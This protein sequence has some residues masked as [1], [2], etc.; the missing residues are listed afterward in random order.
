M[1]NKYATCSISSSNFAR[2]TD[3]RHQGAIIATTHAECGTINACCKFCIT[4][5]FKLISPSPPLQSHILRHLPRPLAH[6]VSY[7][8]P[9]PP[10]PSWFSLGFLWRRAMMR[11]LRGTLNVTW[12]VCVCVCVGKQHRFCFHF[13]AGCISELSMRRSAFC[14]I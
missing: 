8:L 6:P 11:L 4:F 2:C 5:T 14:Q 12:H 3:S 9:F 10:L 7:P 13:H 1:I